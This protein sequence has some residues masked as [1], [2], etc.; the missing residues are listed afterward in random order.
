MP[1]TI[2]LAS[3]KLKPLAFGERLWQQLSHQ[4]S[5]TVRDL[6]VDN[7]FGPKTHG[8]KSRANWAIL[9]LQT[10]HA[11]GVAPAH[12]SLPIS[13]LSYHKISTISSCLREL[14]SSPVCL[15][16]LPLPKVSTPTCHSLPQYL[17]SLGAK[18]S[19]KKL[20]FVKPVL[21]AGDS[22]EEAHTDHVI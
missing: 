11:F 21:P 10:P 15:L 1:D 20:I 17:Q 12:L 22:A 19:P 2:L 14:F 5:L 9:T 18:L 7:K 3:Q 6:S 13:F 4:P 16:E 8:S